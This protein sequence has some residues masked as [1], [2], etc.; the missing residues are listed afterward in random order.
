MD[1]AA[2]QEKWDQRYRKRDQAPA[3]ARVL[4]DNR[5]LLPATGT[6]LDLACGLGGN[7]LCL[8][9]AGLVTQ[10]WDLSPVAIAKLAGFAAE[11]GVA[12]HATVRDVIAAPPAPASFDV[13][14]VSWFLERSLAPALTAA[15]RPGGLLFYQTF[16]AVRVDPIGPD[17]PRFRLDD[18]ELLDLFPLLRPRVYRDEGRLG[19][20]GQGWR[21]AALLVAE[22][23][24][25]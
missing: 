18:G 5:H 20:R 8:A 13:I 3:P 2:L 9:A 22:R 4:A 17:N 14:V 6:A 23:V 25:P 21:N 19:D 1:G 15:L 12:L 24:A 7:A 11:Q 10:A 16:T